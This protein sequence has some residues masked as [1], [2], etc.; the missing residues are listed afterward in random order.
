VAQYINTEQRATVPLSGANAYSHQNDVHVGEHFFLFF[1]SL[2]E[3]DKS[4]N[5]KLECQHVDEEQNVN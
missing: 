2:G 1:F 4:V 3:A 5:V